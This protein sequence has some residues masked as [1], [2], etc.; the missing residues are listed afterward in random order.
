MEEDSALMFIDV[1]KYTEGAIAYH[2]RFNPELHGGTAGFYY[3]KRSDNGEFY[4]Y[5]TTDL[6][7]YD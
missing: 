7:Q 5:P 1:A 6:D 2:L 4:Q 3:A